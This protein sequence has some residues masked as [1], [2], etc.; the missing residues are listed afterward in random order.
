MIYRVIDKS[1]GLWKCDEFTYD[2]ETEIG[3]D[4]IPAQGF[5]HAKWDFDT[6]QW[7]EGATPEEIAA[8]QQQPTEPTIEERVEKVETTLEQTLDVLFGGTV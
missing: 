7:V 5:V 6:Q 2:P 3:L 1:T 8:L 4:V